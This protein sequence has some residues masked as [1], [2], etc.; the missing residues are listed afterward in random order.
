MIFLDS[1][2]SYSIDFNLDEYLIEWLIY[3]DCCAFS[4]DFWSA[5]TVVSFLEIA[6]FHQGI[7]LLLHQVHHLFELSKGSDCDYW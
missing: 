5:K 3:L 4:C 7:R 1:T 6:Y 2:I